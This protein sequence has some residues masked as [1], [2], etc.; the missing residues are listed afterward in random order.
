MG[1]TGDHLFWRDTGNAG[2][3]A[4][5]CLHG[6]FLG[7]RMFDGLS[8]RLAGSWR[9]LV[10]DLPGH[11]RSPLP[12]PLSLERVR[13]ALEYDLLIRQIRELAVVGYSLGTYHALALALEGR[14]RVTRLALLGPLAGLDPEVR[15]AF[16]GHAR[17]VA[18]GMDLAS[19]IEI[20]WSLAVPEPWS[21]AHPADVART[22]ARLREASLATLSAEFQAIGRMVDLRPRLHEL[23]APVLLR[24]GELDR[25]TPAAW[26]EAAARTIPGAVLQV[27]PGVGHLYLVQDA[28]ETERAVWRHLTSTPG[29]AQ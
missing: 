17:S 3:P 24:S 6:Q 28:E 8:E 14:L 22:R 19:L 23:R 7:G 25:S 2:G 15:S 27:V 5:L 18:E 11:G 29:M 13:E 4:V 20:F 21:A 12:S 1:L 16:D 26:A 10:P 9:V